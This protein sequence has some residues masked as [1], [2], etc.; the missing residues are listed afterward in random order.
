MIL[1][2]VLARAASARS[3]LAWESKC[4]LLKTKQPISQRFASVG[5]AMAVDLVFWKKA[6]LGATSM[7]TPKRLLWSVACKEC[8]ASPTKGKE[9][10]AVT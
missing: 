6:S 1:P 4:R 3:K 9:W 8:S 7:D 10:I 5:S 2:I